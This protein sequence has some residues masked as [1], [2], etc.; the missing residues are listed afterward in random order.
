MSIISVHVKLTITSTKKT[1]LDISWKYIIHIQ[2]SYRRG[3]ASLRMFP[4][5]RVL[6]K[7]SDMVCLYSMIVLLL[8]LY[9][10]SIVPLLYLYCPSSV[11]LLYLYC[12]S[13]V[14]SLCL[15]NVHR[16]NILISCRLNLIKIFRHDFMEVTSI[17]DIHHNKQRERQT[18]FK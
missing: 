4:K 15:Q 12:T 6:Y 9:C 14:H 7:P 5:I 1:C 13:I 3:T 17:P 16:L 2:N 11:P 18:Y 8:Y 10:R